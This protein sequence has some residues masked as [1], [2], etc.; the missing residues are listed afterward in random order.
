MTA[1]RNTL[2]VLLII[3]AIDLLVCSFT[4]GVMLFL[5]FQPSLRTDLSSGVANSIS[6][7]GTTSSNAL[8]PVVVII[9]SMNDKQTKFTFEPPDFKFVEERSLRPLHVLI[10]KVPNPGSFSFHSNGPWSFR[11]SVLSQGRFTQV[12]VE[13]PSKLKNLTINPAEEL[14]IKFVCG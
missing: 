1:P 13:C 5:I 14:P 12:P 11:V 3:S 4:A 6:Q 8:S 9:R 2:G 7:K 10:S